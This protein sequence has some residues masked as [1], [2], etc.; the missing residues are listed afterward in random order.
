MPTDQT[1]ELYYVY[2][3]IRPTP[4]GPLYELVNPQG[5]QTIAEAKEFITACQ[6]EGLGQPRTF[7]YVRQPTPAPRLITIEA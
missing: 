5:Y 2:A 1:Q 3:F 6:E 7:L 4:K